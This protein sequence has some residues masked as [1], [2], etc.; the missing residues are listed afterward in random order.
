M[1]AGQRRWSSAAKPKDSSRQLLSSSA[2]MS[3]SIAAPWVTASGSRIAN[4][5]FGARRTHCRP[6]GGLEGRAEGP[7]SDLEGSEPAADLAE[8]GLGGPEVGDGGVDGV[9]EHLERADVGVLAGDPSPTLPLLGRDVLDPVCEPVG[10]V[11]ELVEGVIDAGGGSSLP[12]PLGRV[13]DRGVEH[14]VIFHQRL[15][16]GPTEQ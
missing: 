12:H 4:P 6:N 7:K 2:S 1:V 3:S 10:F 11:H 15:L 16:D 5:P 8:R 14:G 9:P 13:A